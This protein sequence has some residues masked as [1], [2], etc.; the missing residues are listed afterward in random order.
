MPADHLKAALWADIARA[1]GEPRAYSCLAKAEIEGS[2][3][4]PK[5]WWAHER[6][7]LP[8]AR[9]IIRHHGLTL[10]EPPRDA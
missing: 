10:V 3:L 7:S 5:T 1:Y 6:L 2:R 9:A 8:D 4:I